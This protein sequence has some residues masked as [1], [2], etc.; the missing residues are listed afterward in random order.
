MTK[1]T[2]TDA[3]SRYDR[4]SKQEA[5]KL[6]DAGKP[7]YIIACKMRPGMPFSM[8]MNICRDEA[9]G[10]TDFQSVCNNFMFY[11]CSYETG[12]YPAFYTVTERM[13]VEAMTD[14]SAGC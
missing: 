3:A 1:L 12:Y 2:I 13:P 5:R 14:A 4:I 8:G 10:W 11:N 6:W 9:G 7:V